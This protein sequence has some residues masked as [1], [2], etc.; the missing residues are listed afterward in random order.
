[1]KNVQDGDRKVVPKRPTG[2]ITTRCVMASRGQVCLLF[3]E[4]FRSQAVVRFFWGWGCYEII[5]LK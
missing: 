5:S 2:I 3:G 1:L 4:S